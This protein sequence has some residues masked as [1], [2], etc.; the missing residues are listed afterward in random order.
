[1]SL[2]DIEKCGCQRDWCYFADHTGEATTSYSRE[3]IEEGAKHLT[4]LLKEIEDKSK[5][6]HANTNRTRG[7]KRTNVLHSR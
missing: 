6:K 4:E 2:K 7:N 5:E 3:E 1:M